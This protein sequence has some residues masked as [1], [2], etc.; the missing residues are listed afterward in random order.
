[1]KRAANA[2]EFRRRVNASLSRKRPARLERLEDRAMLAAPEIV[3]IS[4]AP[5]S[6]PPVDVS[7]VIELDQPVTVESAQSGVAMFGSQRSRALIGAAID[8][9]GNQIEIDPAGSFSPAKKCA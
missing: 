6:F 7:P 1:M 4:P 9:N 5:N 8:V 2:N 3:S